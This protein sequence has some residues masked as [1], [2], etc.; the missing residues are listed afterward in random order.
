MLGIQALII[1][2]GKRGCSN[3]WMVKIIRHSYG[4][5]AIEY[6]LDLSVAVYTMARKAQQCEYNTQYLNAVMNNLTKA[7]D[8]R[9]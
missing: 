6:F 5:Q 1:F 2:P 9:N 4:I 7:V 3:N 8:K